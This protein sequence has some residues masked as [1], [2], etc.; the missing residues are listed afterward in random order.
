MAAGRAGAVDAQRAR[1]REH[2]EQEHEAIED[3]RITAIE[4]RLHALRRMEHPVSH[5][6]LASQNEGHRTGEEPA[7][8]NTPPTS[9]RMPP[10]P[11]KEKSGGMP[12]SGA[13]GKPNSFCVPCSMKIRAVTIRKAAKA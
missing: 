5:R 11:N 10:T 7:R 4:R 6:H 8:I 12:L 13:A 1:S 3:G 9:S 2:Q